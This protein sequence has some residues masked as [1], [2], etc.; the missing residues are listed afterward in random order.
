MH[1]VRWIYGSLTVSLWLITTILFGLAPTQI[2]WHIAAGNRIDAWGSRWVLWGF[3]IVFSTVMAGL[4]WGAEM[5]RRGPHPV[6]GPHL[7]S[8][9]KWWLLGL[10]VFAVACVAVMLVLIYY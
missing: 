7:S 5:L 6:T 9:E 8:L 10:V 4:L 2:V 1:K 3:P